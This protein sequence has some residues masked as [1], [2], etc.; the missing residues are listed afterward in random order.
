MKTQ[1]CFFH[2][3]FRVTL[4][5]SLMNDLVYVN[6]DQGIHNREK[7]KVVRN[8]KMEKATLG[9]RIPVYK[10]WQILKRFTGSFNQASTSY[11]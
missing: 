8:E 10:I 7:S 1:N 11:F 5:F 9:F 4:S 2:F 6:K 3:S